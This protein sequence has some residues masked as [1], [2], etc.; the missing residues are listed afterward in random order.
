MAGFDSDALELIFG[1]ALAAAVFAAF[2]VFLIWRAYRFFCR[3]RLLGELVYRTGLTWH[4]WVL[5]ILALSWAVLYSVLFWRIS[6][7]MRDLAQMGSRAAPAWI[8][9]PPIFVTAF[10][11]GILIL[12]AFV[13][14][15][16]VEVRRGGLSVYG[17]WDV[18][19]NRVR[20]VLC[21]KQARTLV[22]HDGGVSAVTAP[23]SQ[24]AGFVAALAECGID[25]I[26]VTDDLGYKCPLRRIVWTMIRARVFLAACAVGLAVF[27]VVSGGFYVS[28]APEYAAAARL[29]EAG[30]KVDRVFFHVWWVTFKEGTKP[31][32]EQLRLLHGFPHLDWLDFS[33]T[34]LDDSVTGPLNGLTRLVNLDLAGTQIGDRTVVR[35]SGMRSLRWLNLAETRVTGDGLRHLESMQKLDMLLLSGTQMTEPGMKSIG[36]LSSLKTLSI[37]HTPTKDAWLGPLEKL[38]HLESLS[39][40]KTSITDAGVETLAKFKGLKTLSLSETGITDRCAEA[41]KG[42][43]HLENLH[44]QGTEMSPEVIEEVREAL[45]RVRVLWEDEEEDVAEDK[46]GAEEETGSAAARTKRPEREEQDD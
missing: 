41:L 2:A 34:R 8:W 32:E 29:E 18:S 26:Y 17:T 42:M 31:T 21:A 22:E 35:L 12:M 36:K 14:A 23:R 10:A 4:I 44:I 1:I 20:R 3:E 24:R 33:H 38:P 45:P 43:T 9:V 7:V 39:L 13:L 11:L 15:T 19:W 40:D 46:P 5:A 16:R 30:V 25:A 37:S 28:L 27:F 6:F